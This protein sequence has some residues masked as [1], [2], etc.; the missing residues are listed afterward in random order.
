MAKQIVVS[1][2]EVMRNVKEML[3]SYGKRINKT[4]CEHIKTL[5][6]GRIEGMVEA[7]S[8]AG[9]INADDKAIMK[10][11]FE[12]NYRKEEKVG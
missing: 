8:F 12:A 2:P 9:I 10:L 11:Y 1:K 4:N 5:Y 6:Y 3:D 7:L